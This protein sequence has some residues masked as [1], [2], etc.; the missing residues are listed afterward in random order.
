MSEETIRNYYAAF[1]ARDWDGMCALLTE[2][3]AHDVCQGGRQ[4]GRAAFRKFLDHMDRCYRESVR[5][6]VVMVAPGGQRAAAEFDLDG[7]YL[8]TDAPHPAARGQ[9]YSL[10]VGA[11]FELRDG[12]IA[13]ISNHYNVA[14]WLAQIR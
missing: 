5:D 11:F 6:L 8:S 7:T 13:R 1:N 14:D 9:K 3:V 2:D 10:R 4:A 12:R